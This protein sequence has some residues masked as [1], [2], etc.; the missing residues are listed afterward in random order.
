MLQRQMNWRGLVVAVLLTLNACAGFPL[1]G[2]RAAQSDEVKRTDGSRSEQFPAR[3]TLELLDSHYDGEVLSGRLLIGAESGYVRLDKRLVS[4]ADVHVNSIFECNTGAPVA[5]I[6]A[7]AL[8]PP[9]RE[10]DLLIL[11]PGYMYGTTVR[12]K[13][14]SE[15][16][17]GTGPECIEAQ[18]TV[19]SFEEEAIVSSRV[20]AVRSAV[21]SD[22]GALGDSR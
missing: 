21:A 19:F 16:L 6:M 20:R 5:F 1:F 14:F 12:F 4:R 10:D 8:P 22:G 15:Q 9:S 3:A 11:A 18:F 7:D 17:T 2:R 13:L